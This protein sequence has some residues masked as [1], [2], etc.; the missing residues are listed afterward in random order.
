MR[1]LEG[2]ESAAD[3]QGQERDRRARHEYAD[4][5]PHAAELVVPTDRAIE[6]EASRAGR[7]DRD[8][9][10]EERQVELIAAVPAPEALRPVLAMRHQ[11]AAVDDRRALIL[12]V[13][14]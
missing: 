2:V 1:V 12:D 10:G 5:P 14:H 8:R 9:D 11:T 3:R 6:G 7:R 4:A 13:V